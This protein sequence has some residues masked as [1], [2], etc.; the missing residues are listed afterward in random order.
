MH[1]PTAVIILH[2]KNT[3][4]TVACLSS[5]LA[6]EKK[7]PFTVFVVAVEETEAFMQDLKKKFPLVGGTV[8]S[9]NVG[10]AAGCNI[11]IQKALSEGAAHIILLNND[12]IVSSKLVLSLSSYAQTHPAAGLISPKI[13][14]AAGYEY[15]KERYTPKERGTVIWYAGGILDWATVL[16]SHRG[17]DQVDKG[18][19]NSDCPTDFATGCCML[20][21]REAIDKVGL[22]NE[23][24]FLYFEDVEFSCRVQKAGM[25]VTYY[26]EAHLW[27]KNAASS[28]KPGSK[29]HVYYQTRNR[30][31]FGM[32]YAPF[33]TKIAL[34]RESIRMMMGGGIAGKAVRDY[35]SGRMGIGDL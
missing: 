18:Q 12:T 25:Q 15:H 22:L 10:F 14:F 34:I 35:Y 21:T 32:K 24:Y 9:R 2:Y 29:L 8:T 3:A 4:D 5:L 23:D 17:V 6:K 28:D 1:T 19:F 13:Y 31:A 26:P 30:L 7:L 11:G 27:H 33:R 20:I 16:A